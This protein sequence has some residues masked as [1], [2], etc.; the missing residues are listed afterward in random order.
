MNGSEEANRPVG[1]TYTINT[2]NLGV[3][4]GALPLAWEFPV[5]IIPDPFHT[6]MNYIGMLINH[7][8]RGSGY[9]EILFTTGLAEKRCLKNILSGKGFAK[10]TFNLKATVKALDRLL[11]D[12]FVEQRNTE[13]HPQAPLEVIQA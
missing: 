13:I 12:V 7:K 5:M 2:F 10:A 3:G 8:A 4:M 11:I 6:E 1:Q 9:A